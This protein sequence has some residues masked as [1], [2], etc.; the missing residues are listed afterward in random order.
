MPFK[1]LTSS[2]VSKGSKIKKRS[3]MERSKR[4]TENQK[5][6]DKNLYKLMDLRGKRQPKYRFD[7]DG[8]PIKNMKS[9]KNSLYGANQRGAGRRKT[10]RRR[11]TQRIRKTP[12]RRRKYN[13][14]KYRKRRTRR[15]R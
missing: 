2:M 4:E 3:D 13:K 6:R 7:K 15:R 12:R 10:R 5:R 14:M 11:K 9:K 1:K 8:N